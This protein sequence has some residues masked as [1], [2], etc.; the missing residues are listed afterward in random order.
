MILRCHPKAGEKLEETNIFDIYDIY[1]SI[2]FN[3]KFFLVSIM[4]S[5]LNF[6]TQYIIFF[7]LFTT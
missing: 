5:N 4:Q 7:N 6:E 1:D 2:L 3:G